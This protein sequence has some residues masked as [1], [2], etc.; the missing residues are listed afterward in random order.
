MENQYFYLLF[1]G[2]MMIIWII[3]FMLRTDLRREMLM[4][5]P[6]V[7]VAGPIYEYFHIQDWWRPI[8]IT[9]TDIGPEDFI[10][11]F[12]IGGIG[13]VIYKFIFRKA[14]TGPYRTNYLKL[15]SLTITCFILYSGLFYILRLGSAYSVFISLIL[16]AISILWVRRDLIPKS[17]VSGVGLVIIGSTAYWIFHLIQPGFF[18]N[19]WYLPDVWYAKMFLGIP[20]AEYI[21]FF[22]VGT[23][24]GILFEFWQGKKIID[25]KT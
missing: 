19:F 8:T 7:G 23:F 12:A 13:S 1:S 14:N 6:V 2:F 24:I 22:L 5:S 17:L 10:I 21:W 11:G 25:M 20:I 9:G 15:L 16:G 3:L 18:R 4:V